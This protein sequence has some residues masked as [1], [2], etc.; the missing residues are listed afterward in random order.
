VVDHVLSDGEHRVLVN[1]QRKAEQAD[2]MFS[3][4]SQHINEELAI[5]RDRTFTVEEVIPSWLSQTK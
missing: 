1:L 3:E 4:L 2:K 5:A